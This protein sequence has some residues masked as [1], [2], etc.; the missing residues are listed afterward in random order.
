MRSQFEWRLVRAAEDS[1]AY[2]AMR[3]WAHVHQQRR[4]VS[5]CRSLALQR[6][7]RRLLEDTWLA[8][9]VGTFKGKHVVC[10]GGMEM[11]SMRGGSGVAGWARACSVPE[12]EQSDGDVHFR[13]MDVCLSGHAL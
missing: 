8:W 2:R 4:A 3:A 5:E 10:L 9:W 7:M 6:Q 12:A 1:C 11:D 13:D